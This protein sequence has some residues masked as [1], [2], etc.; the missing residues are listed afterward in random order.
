MKIVWWLQRRLK[1]SY[2]NNLSCG[3]HRLWECGNSAL[4][5][6]FI[7]SHV[8]LFLPSGYSRG[9]RASCTSVIRPYPL[10]KGFQ[11]AAGRCGGEVLV[12]NHLRSV[13]HS[14]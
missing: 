12:L 11:R 9:M 10:M 8:Q 7:H 13:V 6:S 5:N 1:N 4:L 2:E 14:L 3:G